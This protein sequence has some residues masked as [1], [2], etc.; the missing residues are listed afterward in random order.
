MTKDCVYLERIIKLLEEQLYQKDEYIKLLLKQ[1]KEDI[2]SSN[3]LKSIFQTIQANIKNI[4]VD[5]ILNSSYPAK[6]SLIELILFLV[7]ES[8]FNVINK[9]TIQY[10]NLNDDTISSTINE[11]SL[12]VC[13]FIFDALK[14]LYVQKLNY[15]QSTS[16]VQ[17]E[18][19]DEINNSIQNLTI[20]KDNA[21]SL[22]IIK[23]VI[24]L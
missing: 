7:G 16:E 21:T 11:F 24:K 10:K 23:K 9:Y 17:H 14:P 22:N 2:Q 19:E 8:T 4:D 6:N 20:L 18:K 1:K 13:S 3:I 5:S 15:L 12:N